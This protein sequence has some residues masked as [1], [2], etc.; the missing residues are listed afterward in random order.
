MFKK[1]ISLL[2][3]S[4]VSANRTL[5][6]LNADIQTQEITPDLKEQIIT[7]FFESAESLVEKSDE[8]VANLAK[9]IEDMV[10]HNTN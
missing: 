2:F 10:L 6:E 5:K 1:S 8:S 4:L 7:E 9:N 3:A